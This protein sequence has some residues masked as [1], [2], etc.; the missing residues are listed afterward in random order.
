MGR[1]CI[2]LA[3]SGG[4]DESTHPLHPYLLQGLSQLPL[5]AY[6]RSANR[7][8]SKIRVTEHGFDSMVHEMKWTRMR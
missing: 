2:P 4:G 6:Q 7:L 8:R 5:T 3:G 1:P